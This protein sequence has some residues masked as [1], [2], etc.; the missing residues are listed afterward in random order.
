MKILKG[1]LLAIALLIL[2][3]IAYLRIAVHE[4]AP[5]E[6]VEAGAELYAQQM[7]DAVNIKAWDTL[8]IVQWTFREQNHYLWDKI[9]N[10]ALIRWDDYIVHLD[11]DAVDGAAFKNDIKLEGKAKEKAIKKAWALWCNDSFWLAAPFKIRDL[12][13]KRYFA[14]DKDG[15]SG[16]L[17]R[18]ESGGV[19]PG[20]QYLWFLDQNGLPTGYKMWVSIIPIG[21]VYTT[22]EDWTT[23]PGGA[24][25]AATHKGNIGGL[26]L[27]LSN[28]KGGDS[29]QQF[30]H[31][32]NPIDPS[33]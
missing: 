27:H 29:W 4:P 14:K 26:V 3:V 31:S 25:L 10:N 5:T 19:T 33:L 20:D 8:P 7:L 1:I 21:G 9:N 17:I 23:L 22:W 18:Y 30:G 24:K 6:V 11:M 12:G 16:L 2:L 13:T 28:I 32:S 15:K